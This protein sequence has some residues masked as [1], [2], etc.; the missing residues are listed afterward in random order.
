MS[1]KEFFEKN[2][3]EELKAIYRFIESCDFEECGKIIDEIRCVHD[4]LITFNPVTG[5]LAKVESVC[6]NG[7]SIQ[8]NIEFGAGLPNLDD[9]TFEKG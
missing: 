9:I 2:R 8:L 3:Q 5:L 6:L 1:I 7:E 4:N